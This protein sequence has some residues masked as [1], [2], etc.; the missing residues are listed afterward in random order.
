MRVRGETSH[1]GRQRLFPFWQ[2]VGQTLWRRGHTNEN[3]KTPQINKEKQLN[4]AT[5]TAISLKSQLQKRPKQPQNNY[6]GK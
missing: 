2:N 3:V 6:F 5:G 4:P 1:T